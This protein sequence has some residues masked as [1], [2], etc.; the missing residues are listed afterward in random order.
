MTGPGRPT[1]EDIDGPDFLMMTEYLAGGDG[2]SLAA[3]INDA[4][5]TKKYPTLDNN[6]STEAHEKRIRRTLDKLTKLYTPYQSWAEALR[7]HR[8]E[9]A[10]ILP[11]TR[12]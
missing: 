6:L 2:R 4:L 12:K 8:G 10:K 7:A 1:T 3:I 9:T 11:F 5:R